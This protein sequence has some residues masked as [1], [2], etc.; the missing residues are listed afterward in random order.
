MQ[1]VS[2]KLCLKCTL[3]HLGQA[4]VLFTETVKGY[5][6]HKYLGLGHLAEAE[7]ECISKY[8][9][10]ANMIRKTRLSID[11]EEEPTY[12]IMELIQM[13]HDMRKRDGDGCQ[14]C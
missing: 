9:N 12:D 13:V 11:A 6:M 1:I 5:P 8:P 14:T 4:M 10:I 7:D 3:K 2:R